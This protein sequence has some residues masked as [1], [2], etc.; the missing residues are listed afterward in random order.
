[1]ISNLMIILTYIMVLNKLNEMGIMLVSQT[2]LSTMNK[3]PAGIEDINQQLLC[4]A[5]MLRQHNSAYAWLPMGLRVMRKLEQLVRNEMQ[6]IGAVEMRIPGEDEVEAT[7]D[8]MRDELKSYKQLSLYVYQI[9]E[10]FKSAYSFDISESD[11][12]QSSQTM[13]DVHQCILS[14]VGLDGNHKGIS[15]QV[16]LGEMLD[17]SVLNDQG[18][19]TP[20]QVAKHILNMSQIIFDIVQREHDKHGIIWPQNIA[21]FTI[22]LLPM[23]MYKSYRVREFAE[24]LYRQLS[25]Q[26]P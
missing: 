17:L 24:K 23:R 26:A 9:R 14:A 4:R 12:E 19:S 3:A 21:P 10:G 20:V 18:R 7:M 5:G 11:L 22:A 1:M 6:R 8:V 2:F 25:D 16:S 13:R 15:S